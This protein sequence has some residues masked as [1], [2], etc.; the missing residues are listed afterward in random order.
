MVQ[1][2]RCA[3]K[4][5]QLPKRVSGAK[6]IAPP[7]AKINLITSILSIVGGSSPPPSRTHAVWS[8]HFSRPRHQKISVPPAPYST[9]TPFH[10]NHSLNHK[11]GGGAIRSLDPRGSRPGARV[12]RGKQ[13][14]PPTRCKWC[15]SVLVSVIFLVRQTPQC[16][17]RCK[18][19]RGSCGNVTML[20]PRRSQQESSPSFFPWSRGQTLS[21]YDPFS[22]TGYGMAHRFP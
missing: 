5:P 9:D 8:G 6:P 12:A 11:V 21:E 1:R 10:T 4:V 3:R 13:C 2:R 17:K 19:G 7:T 14:A 18:I 22:H 15:W 16:P 20:R